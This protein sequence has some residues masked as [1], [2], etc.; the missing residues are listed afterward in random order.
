MHRVL[1]SEGLM[2]LTVLGLPAAVTTLAIGFCLLIFNGAR[3]KVAIL[4]SVRP[5]R[6]RVAGDL[7]PLTPAR[8]RVPVRLRGSS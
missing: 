2:T 4:L 5:A 6:L 7:L 1:L 8:G 3:P